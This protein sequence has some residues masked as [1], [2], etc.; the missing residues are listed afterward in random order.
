M[1][2]TKH[3]LKD[4]Y[5]HLNQ[6]KED[7]EKGKVYDAERVFTELIGELNS[8]VPNTIAISSLEKTKMTEELL[9]DLKCA[10]NRADKEGWVDAEGLERELEVLD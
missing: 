4:I 7:I 1:K 3:Y 5:A 2:E 6:S 9:Q 8:Y 10:E